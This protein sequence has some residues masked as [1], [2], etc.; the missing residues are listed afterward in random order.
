MTT[1]TLLTYTFV[2]EFRGGTYCSQVQAINVDKAI[3]AWT[4]KLKVEK[5]EIK[6]LGDKTISEIIVLVKDKEYKPIPLTNLVNVW[7]TSYP[8]NQGSLSVNII[9]TDSSI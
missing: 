8:T 9:Q 4:E 6:Q 2:V 3:V 5:S 1:T 7:F